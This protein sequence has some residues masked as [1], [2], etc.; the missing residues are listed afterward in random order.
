MQG[1]ISPPRSPSLREGVDLG[2]GTKRT[3]AANLCRFCPSP[4][5]SPKVLL[6]TLLWV[7]SSGG[8][9][10]PPL[11]ACPEFRGPLCAP[12]LP[13][14]FLVLTSQRGWV[15]SFP[16]SFFLSLSFF[17]SCGTWPH[18]LKSV[19]KL[20]ASFTDSSEYFPFGFWKDSL[21]TLLTS[22]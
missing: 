15:L 16:P 21:S 2:H 14:L 6:L 11:G 18:F 20:P 19:P 8:S 10:L 5:P 4:P 7:L 12:A 9:L 22:T 3:K 17:C 1:N 13:V